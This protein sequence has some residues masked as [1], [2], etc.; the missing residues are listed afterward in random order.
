M[1]ALG[2]LI[3]GALGCSR[4][5]HVSGEGRIRYAFCLEHTLAYLRAFAA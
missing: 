1:T 3:C 2:T 5:R 4:R